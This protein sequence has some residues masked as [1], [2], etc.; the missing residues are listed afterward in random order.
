V[1]ISYLLKVFIIAS[2]SWLSLTNVFLLVIFGAT[3]VESTVLGEENPDQ[4]GGGADHLSR[5]LG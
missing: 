5:G 3:S 4:S 2:I 1:F